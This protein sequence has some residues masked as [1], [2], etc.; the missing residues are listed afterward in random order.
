M[1]KEIHPKQNEPPPLTGTTYALLVISSTT[2]TA[3]SR[4]PIFGISV[5]AF[6]R[7]RAT[8]FTLRTRASVSG[9]K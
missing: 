1:Q 4:S 6:N 5:F 7:R 8:A 3:H 2:Y 9:N